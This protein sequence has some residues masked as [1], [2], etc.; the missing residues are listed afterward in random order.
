MHLLEQYY[1]Y[2]FTKHLITN[3]NYELA[4]FNTKKSEIWLIKSQWRSTKVIRLMQR[5][6]DW[7][8]HLKND[9]AHLFQQV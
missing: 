8:N 6:F 4:H 1:L 3:E 9:I 5:G 7:R 2:D